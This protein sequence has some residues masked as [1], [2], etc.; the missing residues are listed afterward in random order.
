MSRFLLFWLVLVGSAS[1]ALAQRVVTTRILTQPLG[2]RFWVDGVPYR[3]P[4]A[5]NWTEG[6][7]HTISTDIEQAIFPGERLKFTGWLDSAGNQLGQ[8]ESITVSASSAI[9]FIQLNFTKE[10]LLRVL[11]YSCREVV[12]GECRPPGTVFVGGAAFTS[13]VEQ[14][15]PADS[16]VQL[17][18]RPGPGF[19]FVNWGHPSGFSTALTYTHRMTSAVTFANIFAP[20]KRITLLSEPAELLLA[21]DR[22]PS[23]SP[24]EVDWGTGT[25]HILGA[26]SPQAEKDNSSRLWVFSHWSNGAR[27][28]DPYVVP[29]NT[30]PETITGYFVRGAQVSFVT[31]P[32][33]L[34]LRVEGRENWPAYNFVWGVGMKYQVSAPLEQ[35]D[36]RGRRWVFKGWSN[37]GPATQE[38]QITAEHVTTG[39]RLIA[40][41]EPQSRLNITT[42]PP[43]LP[44]L[45]DGVECRASCSIDREAGAL[46]QLVAPEVI[47]LS[48]N[49]RLEFQGWSDGGEA[50]RSFTFTDRPETNLVATYRSVHRLTT[51]AEPND[52]AA[53]FRVDP[54]S[55]DGFFPAD[56][57]VTVTAEA[58]PGYRFRRWDGD[59]SGT[60]GAGVVRMSG[61]RLVRAVLEPVPYADPAGV[62]NAAGETPEI[63]VAPGSIASVVGLNLAGDSQLGPQN[64]LAQTLGGVTLRIDNRFL[65]LVSVSP[66]QI[67]FQVPSDLAE[68]SYQVAARWNNQPEVT[69]W[70]RVVRN[71]PGLFPRILN[72]EGREVSPDAPARRGEIVSIFGTGFGPYDRVVVDGFPLPSSFTYTCL[73]PVEV[74]VGDRLVEPIWAGGVAGQVGIASARFRLP[75]DLTV[76]DQTV[77]VRVR[78]NGRSSNPI[79]LRID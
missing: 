50:R 35:V 39:F 22:T 44:V 71:A 24:V 23:R 4:Q 70:M 47:P 29:N 14:W 2:A 68:G 18:A 79:L 31:N 76:V 49:S 15:L 36:A 66:E 77:A 16:S 58:R 38:I 62:R 5:F 54:A 27:I 56:V 51:M 64:P 25:T 63:V 74:W 6:S 30:R 20:A 33:G 21:P 43:N 59:L 72:S 13:D 11:F 8:A 28:N 10:Y 75:E 34:R 42:L 3:S 67:N 37:Q 19:V 46:V 40:N 1:E 52:K 61:P 12:P 48:E 73:D 17:S 26:V 9:T 32:P 65:P 41:Y 69:A 7:K 78:I 57:S 53:I 60:F 45:I 55:P